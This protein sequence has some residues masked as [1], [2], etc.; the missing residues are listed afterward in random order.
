MWQTSAAL[1]QNHSGQPAAVESDV[2]LLQIVVDDQP[3]SE[4]L[5]AY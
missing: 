1:A 2:L 4:V 3:M 5:N